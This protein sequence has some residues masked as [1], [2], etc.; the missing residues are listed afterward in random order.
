TFKDGT[1]VGT[2]FNGAIIRCI[3]TGTI[4][5]LANEC[6]YQHLVISGGM[7]Q[8]IQGEGGSMDGIAINTSPSGWAV[9]DFMT[10]NDLRCWQNYGAVSLHGAECNG[11]RI[12]NVRVDT[13]GSVQRPTIN[14]AYGAPSTN[15]T[16]GRPL[17]NMGDGAVCV[18]SRHLGADSATSCYYASG[19]GCAY[20]SDSSAGNTKPGMPDQTQS[21]SQSQYYECRAEGTTNL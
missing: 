21:G 8:G 5:N 15:P 14:Q 4:L 16:T 2:A 12:Y 18:W 9:C 10:V 11:G 19:N 6:T 17:G 20:V 1:S 3:T 7:G 13:P